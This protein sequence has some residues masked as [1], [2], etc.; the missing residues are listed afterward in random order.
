MNY[1]IKQRIFSWSD[2]FE[3]YDEKGNEVYFVEGE[4]FSLGKKLHLYHSSGKE[5]AYVEQQLFR[6]RP[7]YSIYREGNRVTDVVKEISFFSAEYSA[8]ELGWTVTGDF[9]GHDYQITNGN[10]I[11]ATVSKEWFTLG[12]AYEISVSEPKNELDALAIVLIVD[13]CLAQQD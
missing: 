13:A 10:E 11:I 2:R 9:F 4:V 12:D 8:E 6:F 5:V 3:I 1:Y 7:R